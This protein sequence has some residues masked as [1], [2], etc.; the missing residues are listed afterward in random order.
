MKSSSRKR[1]GPRGDGAQAREAILAAA[2]EQFGARG[3]DAATLRG[4][5]TAAGV[6]VALVS[7]YFGAKSD[8]F[9]AALHL[10]IS[11]A[12]ILDALLAAGTD[13]LG[14]RL[15]E[16][17]LAVWDEPAS[18]AQLISV[19]R[20]ATSQFDML[21]DFL[22]QQIVPRLA[23]AIDAPDAELRATAVASQVLGLLLARYVLRVEPL[24]SAPR[25]EVAAL[26]APTI[27]R[28]VDG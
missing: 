19:L 23:A 10:P 28:Y 13:G 1:R 14:E 20:S 16:R 24:A 18:G 17:L 15:F 21:R 25:A 4:I 2:R 22:T 26:Y 12:Q 9:V 8:L 6:D 5:A 3:Y 27:Q 11:P 7:Y